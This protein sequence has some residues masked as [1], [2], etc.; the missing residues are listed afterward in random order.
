MAENTLLEILQQFF[1]R[2]VPQQAANLNYDRYTTDSRSMS[3]HLRPPFPSPLPNFELTHRGLVQ[4]M[5]QAMSNPTVQELL[6]LLRVA[7]QTVVTNHSIPSVGEKMRG[8]PLGTAGFY[9]KS[10]GVMSTTSRRNYDTK[11]PHELAHVAFAQWPGRIPYGIPWNEGKF[12]PFKA[13][14]APLEEYAADLVSGGR[15][16]SEGGYEQPPRQMVE[17]YLQDLL[18]Y[19]R[20]HSKSW[21][22]KALESVPGAASQMFG[23]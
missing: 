20:E 10:Q 5:S 22:Q 21:G 15:A 2:E 14:A 23:R 9:D 4:P 7:P 6:S 18:D 3:D 19:A 11:T 1:S 8:Y 16:Y 12:G 13:D 17:Q